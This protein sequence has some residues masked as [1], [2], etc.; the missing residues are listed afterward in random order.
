MILLSER[1]CAHFVLF[2]YTSI[3]IVVGDLIIS[4]G[5]IPLTDLIDPHF[6]GLDCQCHMP[7]SIFCVQWFEVKRGCSFCW[8][9]WSCLPS[10]FKFSFHN[11]GVH[12]RFLVRF[13]VAQ[14]LDYCVFYVLNHGCQSTQRKPPTS[15]QVTVT[16]Y[17]IMLYRVHLAMIGIRTHNLSGDSHWLHR[18][19]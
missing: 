2:V 19:L 10:L 3:C 6:Y 8:Y 9:W 14:S 16:L 13:L 7:W 15:P 17:H 11:S 18:K 4:N 5:G 1:E 12:H